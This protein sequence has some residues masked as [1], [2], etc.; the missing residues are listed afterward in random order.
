VGRAKGG[1]SGKKTKWVIMDI[2][3]LPAYIPDV[4]VG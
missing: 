3:H 2:G 1:H 4:Q